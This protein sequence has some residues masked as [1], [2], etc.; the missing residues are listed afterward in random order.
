MPNLCALLRRARWPGRDCASHPIDPRSPLVA[1]CER[2]RTPPPR[3]SALRDRR[4]ARHD[5]AWTR[6][7]QHRPLRSRSGDSGM[8]E[9]Q[10][11][12][13]DAVPQTNSGT[14]QGG[15]EAIV[16]APAVDERHDR[17]SG[18]PE[19]F[20]N[21]E[22]SAIRTEAL[23]K[24]YLELERKLGSGMARPAE[25]ANSDDSMG[26]VADLGRARIARAVSDRVA[27]RVGRARSRDQ[28]QAASGGVHRAPSAAGLRPRGGPP[29]PRARRGAG[30]IPGGARGGTA[31]LP[32]RRRDARG[33]PRR[34]RSRPGDRRTSPRKSS[35]RWRRATTACSPSIR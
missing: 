4:H 12:T 28:C 2:R 6:L 7:I 18:V 25:D 29:G 10:A 22:T 8:S 9:Q 3:R 21:P 31:R 35:R 27:S 17:P 11:H 24:S 30:R 33:A 34:G 20:W 15:P 23:L 32:L 16:T 13:V 1:Q 19:K 14:G 5:R 26:Q